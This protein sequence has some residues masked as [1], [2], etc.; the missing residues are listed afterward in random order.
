MYSNVRGI[1]FN[2][3]SFCS[4]ANRFDSVF[5]E[6]TV[7]SKISNPFSTSTLIGSEVGMSPMLITSLPEFS[8]HTKEEVRL[9][10]VLPLN[11]MVKSDVR[12]NRLD[13]SVESLMNDTICLFFLVLK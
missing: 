7:K 12:G 3:L 11:C 9:G 4:N 6:N 10:I 2:A 8:T 1:E 5:I 13:M